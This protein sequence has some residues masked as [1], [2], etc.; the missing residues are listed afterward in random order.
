MV[1]VTPPTP[2][3]NAIQDGE[4]LVVK[5]PTAQE[6]QTASTVV[7]VTTLLEHRSAKTVKMDGW[8]QIATTHAFMV[9]KLHQ[10]LDSVS[11]KRVGLV[12]AVT[13]NAV[14]MERLILPRASA[15]ATISLASGVQS[16]NSLAALAMDLVLT[17]SLLLKVYV[18]L[19]VLSAPSTALLAPEMVSAM[20]QKRD[21]NAI[22]AG[23]DLVVRHL[24]AQKNQIACAVVSVTTLL[25]T[26]SAR[27]VKVLG[28]VL[29]AMT[30]V[31]TV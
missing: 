22:L 26:Q 30:H 13:L 15:F 12:S 28:W 31:F 18:I 29:V 2:P 3:V 1:T 17:T 4:D 20:L 27:T 10:T 9:L 8:H 5:L 19:L 7:T 23:R 25:Q 24:I 14:V 6:N 11:V 21:A 16:V